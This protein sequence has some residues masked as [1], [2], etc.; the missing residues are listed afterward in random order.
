MVDADELMQEM[1]QTAKDISQE[2]GK[3]DAMSEEESEQLYETI[4]LV[5][6][7][8]DVIQQ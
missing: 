6:E 3:I 5:V 7:M 4:G 8:L 2:L 1:V